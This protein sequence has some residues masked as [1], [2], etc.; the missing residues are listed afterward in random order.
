MTSS[1]LSQLAQIASLTGA[2]PTQMMS[3]ATQLAQYEQ[4]VLRAY[5]GGEITGGKGG[6][7]GPA[8]GKGSQ[9]FVSSFSSNIFRRSECRHDQHG[10]EAPDLS[11]LKISILLEVP[12]LH[13]ESQATK[14]LSSGTIP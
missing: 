12:I 5:I 9:D 10:L 8:S 2:S 11:R 13:K 6:G 14:H 7:G 1:H 4:D 3:Q